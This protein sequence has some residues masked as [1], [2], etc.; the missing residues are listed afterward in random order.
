MFIVTGRRGEQQ[1]AKIAIRRHGCVGCPSSGMGVSHT[2]GASKGNTGHAGGG[3][4]IHGERGEWLGGFMK[5]M[6]ICT[7]IK[8][9]IKA[10]YRALRSAKSLGFT[11][12]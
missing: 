9:E 2:D 3:G 8:Y 7:S 4:V 10:A 1:T 12:V 5:K 6:S 11:E